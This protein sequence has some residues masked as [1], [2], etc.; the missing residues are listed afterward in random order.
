MP[1]VMEKRIIFEPGDILKITG[2]L[3]SL[4]EGFFDRCGRKRQPPEM[5]FVWK[6]LGHG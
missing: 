1:I 2:P 5:P 4:Q 3:L 6:G